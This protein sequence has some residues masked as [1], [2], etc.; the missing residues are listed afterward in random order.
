MANESSL[1]E[2]VSVLEHDMEVI[3][4]R[5]K[6]VSKAG[7]FIGYQPDKSVNSSPITLS[8]Y[9]AKV[10]EVS[11]GLSSISRNVAIKDLKQKFLR[12][13]KEECIA[14]KENTV[15]HIPFR[16]IEVQAEFLNKEKW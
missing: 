3:S 5:I 16:S 7:L 1:D 9:D 15:R 6:I 2:L 8:K 14:R 10:F 13:L 4:F 12:T 11:R